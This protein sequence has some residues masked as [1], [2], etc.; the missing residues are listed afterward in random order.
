MD[1]VNLVQVVFDRTAQNPMEDAAIFTL[2]IRGFLTALPDSL[3]ALDD[4][5]RTTFTTALTTWFNAIKADVTNKV[6]LV[7]VRYYELGDTPE[8]DMGPPVKVDALN[9]SA[10]SYTHLTLPTTRRV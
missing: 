6:K 5:D 7:Q 10:V 1:N 4:S 3:G 9:I 2:H 8:E